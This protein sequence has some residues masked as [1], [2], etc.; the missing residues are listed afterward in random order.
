M[1]SHTHY[2]PP[3]TDSPDG[4]IYAKP[5]YMYM[6]IRDAFHQLPAQ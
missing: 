1:V 2:T 4:S 3:L 6:D 5:Q